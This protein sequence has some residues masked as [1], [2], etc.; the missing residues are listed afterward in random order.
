MSSWGRGRERST[1]RE[2]MWGP[3]KEAGRPEPRL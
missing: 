2:G 1:R 3:E